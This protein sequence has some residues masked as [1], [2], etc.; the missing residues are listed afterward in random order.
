MIIGKISAYIV[1]YLV[2]FLPGNVPDLLYKENKALAQLYLFNPTTYHL[3]K[4]KVSS[5]FELEIYF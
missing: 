5:F 4:L 1:F 2:D 3:L